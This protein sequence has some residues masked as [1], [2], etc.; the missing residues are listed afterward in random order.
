[1]YELSKIVVPGEMLADQPLRIENT[2]TEEG[3]TYST[4]L[5]VFEEE[6]SMLIPLEGLWYPGREDVIIGIIDDARM[7]S[8]SVELNAPYKG[9]IVAKYVEGRLSR[10]DIIE[11][12]VRMLD[13]TKTVVLT[14]PRKLLGGKIIDVSP[15]KVARIIGK[16]NTMID[17][18]KNS[19]KSNIIVGMNGRVWVKGGN[20]ALATNAILRIQE[21][22]HTNGLTERIKVMLQEGHV[23]TEKIQGE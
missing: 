1:V 14:H 20:I 5:G 13:D 12:T 16:G 19:T 2:F 15:S 21:E 22:A 6:R 18:L 11:A 3:K 7:T 23:K 10:G 4:V 17:Q 9:I 8:Y